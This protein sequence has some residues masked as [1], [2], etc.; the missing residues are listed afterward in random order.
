M[1]KP[2]TNAEDLPGN[3]ILEEWGVIIIFP[4]HNFC[5]KHN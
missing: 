5:V 3:I 4:F 2:Q 1:G